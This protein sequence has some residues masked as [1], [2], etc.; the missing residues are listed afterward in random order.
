MLLALL[1]LLCQASGPVSAIV[2]LQEMGCFALVSLTGDHSYWFTDLLPLH[3][4]ATF[5]LTFKSKET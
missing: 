5:K 2:T 4:L 1:T 3:N